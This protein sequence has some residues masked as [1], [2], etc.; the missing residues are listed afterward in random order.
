MSYLAML[1]ALE[2]ES[3][4]GQRERGER[5]PTYTQAA[6]CDAC[7]PVWLWPGAPAR[8]LACPWC[9]NRRAGKP[10][11]QPPTPDEVSTP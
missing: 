3:V 1:R 6:T 2:A 11:P 7:G 4:R 9:F 10:V 8:V 5:P